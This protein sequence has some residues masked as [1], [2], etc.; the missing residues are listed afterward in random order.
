M[1][2]MAAVCAPGSLL[3]PEKGIPSLTG[4]INIHICLRFLKSPINSRVFLI[5]E[6]FS[7]FCSDM[8]KMKEGNCC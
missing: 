2:H 5:S 7:P 4:G 8:L 1:Q 6:A 3:L